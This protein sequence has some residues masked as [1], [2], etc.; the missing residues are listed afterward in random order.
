VT[1][2]VTP[3]QAFNRPRASIVIRLFRTGPAEDQSKHDADYK[4][5]LS[6]DKLA[7]VS[8]TEKTD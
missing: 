5:S 3:A 2:G 4:N 6:S 8:L 7:F 1:L